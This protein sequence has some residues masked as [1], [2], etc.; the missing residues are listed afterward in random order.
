MRC[1]QSTCLL[2]ARALRAKSAVDSKRAARRRASQSRPAILACVVATAAG[3]CESRLAFG[4]H[5]ALFPC[6]LKVGL[7]SMV[8]PAA[9]PSWCQPR[10]VPLSH[11]LQSP[12]RCPQCIH[13][14]LEWPRKKRRRCAADARRR[15][16]ILETIVSIPQAVDRYFRRSLL[17]RALWC[18]VSLMLGFYAGNMVSLAFGALAINDV[19]AAVVTVAVTEVISREFYGQWPDPSLWL[20]F[21]NFFKIGVT[22]A[23]MSDA[24]KLGS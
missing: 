15:T 20:M 8:C 24:M 16:R 1:S 5:A 18:M 2:A 14:L 4:R 11:I 23:F 12:R 9:V 13:S 21:A 7:V 17:R 10:P 3:V 6:C 19:V 22:W